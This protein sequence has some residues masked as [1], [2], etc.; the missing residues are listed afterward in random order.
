[1]TSR[2][3]SIRTVSMPT[4]PNEPEKRFSAPW[5]LSIHRAKPSA[6]VSAGWAHDWV[7]PVHGATPKRP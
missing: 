4:R 1:M 3:P 6:P 7:G 5:R 2:C